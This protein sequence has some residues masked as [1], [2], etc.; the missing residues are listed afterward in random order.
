MLLP[1]QCRD[2][3]RPPPSCCN[4]RQQKE[5]AEKEAAH[6]DAQERAAAAFDP[7]KDPGAQGDPFK[8][9]FLARLPRDAND[10]KIRREFEEFGP[11][12]RL[13]VVADRQGRSRGYAFVEF[14]RSDDMKRAYKMANYRNMDGRRIVV[15]VE[16]GRT[17]PEWRPRRLGGGLGGESRRTKPKKGVKVVPEATP[18]RGGPE[19]RYRMGEPPRSVGMYGDRRRDERPPREYATP[20]DYRDL[21]GSSSRPA[22]GDYSGR[23]DDRGDRDRERSDR[24]RDRYGDR[25][26]ERSRERRGD[27]DGNRERERGDRRRSRSPRDRGDG[28]GGERDKRRRRDEPGQ[29]EGELLPPPPAFV[30]GGA[31]P[32]PPSPP[33]AC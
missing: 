23:R 28:Y 4:L 20:R 10:R 8:T 6:K 9:L 27:R 12:S 14:E 13:R 1:S 16:R 2:V 26:R 24:D 21:G 3:Q 25:K 18:M 7:S 22:G 11:I 32:P 15:D 19:D 17:V 5:R 30:S 33:M 29:E 31:L